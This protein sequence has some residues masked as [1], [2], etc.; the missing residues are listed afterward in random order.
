M[1]CSESYSATRTLQ[2]FVSC[3]FNPVTAESPG[4]LRF[5]NQ[6]DAN[7]NSLTYIWPKFYQIDS[8][9]NLSI[10]IKLPSLS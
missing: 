2:K 8:R 4:Q 10:S 7:I 9:T 1:L 3:L 6:E 5:K